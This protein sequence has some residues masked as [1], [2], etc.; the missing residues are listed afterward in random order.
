[1]RKALVTG[2]L[3]LA[4]ILIVVLFT[5]LAVPLVL[6]STGWLHR[7]EY[8]FSGSLTLDQPPEQVY[9]LLTDYEMLPEWFRACEAVEIRRKDDHTLWVGTFA[10]GETASVLGMEID[11]PARLLWRL[12][13]E[14]RHVSGLWEFDLTPQVGGTQLSVR[15]SG[16]AHHWVYRLTSESIIDDEEHI[17]EFLSS[18]AVESSQP[19]E[20]RCNEECER[21]HNRRMQRTFGR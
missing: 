9:G 18:L 12:T 1:M 2:C 21:I 8:V 17:R 6:R 7:S 13:S 11:P 3:A 20:S 16:V 4:A 15:A 5:R 10:N 19:L 14:N